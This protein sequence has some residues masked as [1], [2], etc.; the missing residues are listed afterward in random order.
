MEKAV[1]SYD[2]NQIKAA[3]IPQAIENLGYEA[4]LEKR[5]LKIKGMTCAA[6]SARVERKLKATPGII[7][8]V[9]NLATEKAS[10]TYNPEEL[11]GPDLIRLIN[12]AGYEGEEIADIGAAREEEEKE[13]THLRQRNLFLFCGLFSLPLLL[14]M[15]F[16]LLSLTWS[17]FFM[18]PYLQFVLATPVQVV[19]GWQF[20]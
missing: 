8:A 1:I 3:D 11:S 4:L 14:G 6:C 10:V 17:H 19:G 18:N 16:E 7:D 12:E 20:Y 9:V 13:K 2:P 15:F 5:E